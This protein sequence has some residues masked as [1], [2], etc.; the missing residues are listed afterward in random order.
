MRGT[1][2]CLEVHK[3]KTA[4]IH[5]QDVLDLCGLLLGVDFG[6]FHDIG[7]VLSL[8]FLSVIWEQTLQCEQYINL[9]VLALPDEVCLSTA[10]LLFVHFLMW[11]QLDISGSTTW[12]R[13]YMTVD[14]DPVGVD[15]TT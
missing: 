7:A 4:A 10:A 11:R 13:S 3:F 12:H 9:A 8:D 14:G 15:F 1:Y 5:C 2:I 6:C